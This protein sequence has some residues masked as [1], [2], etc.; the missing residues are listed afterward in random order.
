[1][2]L[3]T[4]DALSPRLVDRVRHAM[5]P[6]WARSVVVRRTVSAVL[7]IAAVVVTVA[8]H[9]SAQGRAVVV[10]AHDLLPGHALVGDDV[11]VRE[12]PGALVPHGALRLTADGL[13]RTV[14]GRVNAGEILTDARLL[15]SRLPRGLT[16]RD[17]AR[18][19]PVRLADESV[20]SLLR[21]GDVVDVLS[22]DDAHDDGDDDSGASTAVLATGAVVALTATAADGEVLTGR[23]TRSR[24]VLLAMDEAAAHRVARAGLD[25]SLAVVVH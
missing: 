25:A 20:T 2:H 3:L 23:G 16:G 8:G 17:D 4:R 7:V 13:G 19:V 5:R 21:E 14:A 15:S 9:R 11:T 10:A 22:A 24:P 18:L 12:V 1:M 6:G